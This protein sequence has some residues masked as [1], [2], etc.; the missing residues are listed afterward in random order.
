MAGMLNIPAID[1]N[2]VVVE[3]NL[4]I[5]VFVG[6]TVRISP[7]FSPNHLTLYAASHPMT[8]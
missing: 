8:P 7:Q 6:N 1:G 3:I 5:R 2:I 4:K